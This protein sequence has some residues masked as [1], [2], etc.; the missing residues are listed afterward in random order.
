[1]NRIALSG[2]MCSGKSTVAEYL[3]FKYGFEIVSFADELK[4]IARDVFELHSKN[5]RVLQKLGEE[6][7]GLDP[8]IWIRP[9]LWKITDLRDRPI[10]IPDLRYLNEAETLAS[11]DFAIVR[12]QV[13]IPTQRGRAIRFYGEGDLKRA[14]HISEIELDDYNFDYVLD[15]SL[16]KDIMLAQADRLVSKP[17]PGIIERPWT[18]MPGHNW[19][20]GEEEE[21]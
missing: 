8:D 6:M 20:F 3:K 4:R 13:D 5:R 12:V 18:I 14:G 21:D 16:T 9:V 11:I 2:K 1:M 15:G 7:R 10:V 19:A 17:W